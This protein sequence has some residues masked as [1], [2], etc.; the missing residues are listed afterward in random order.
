MN[1]PLLKVRAHQN[2]TNERCWI[3]P[4]EEESEE[5][6]IGSKARYSGIAS[7]VS[8]KRLSRITIFS[9]KRASAPDAPKTTRSR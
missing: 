6:G 1:A 7:S 4:C 5:T 3:R 2:S 8:I 9:A